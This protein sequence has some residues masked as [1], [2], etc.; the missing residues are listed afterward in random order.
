MAKPQENRICVLKLRNRE[1]N[2]IGYTIAMVD[3]TGILKE[4]GVDNTSYFIS[5]LEPYYEFVNWKYLDDIGL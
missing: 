2:E 4:I 5:Y 1:T 3:D